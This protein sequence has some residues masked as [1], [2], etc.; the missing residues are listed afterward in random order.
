MCP[1]QEV[2]DKIKTSYVQND[3]Y[4]PLKNAGFQGTILLTMKTK[5]PWLIEIGKSIRRERKRKGLSQEQLA[6]LASL[7]RTYLGGIERGERNV[8]ALNLVRIAAALN[9]EVAT[10]FPSV[11]TLLEIPSEGT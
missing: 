4:S 10:F 5:H 8:A 3:T 6:A 9:V 11:E 2:I 7:D 1:F